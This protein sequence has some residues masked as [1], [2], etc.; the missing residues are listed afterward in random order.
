MD[1]ILIAA[2]LLYMFV[3]IIS[4]LCLLGFII[5]LI[6]QFAGILFK[7]TL[8]GIATVLIL[9]TLGWLIA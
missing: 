9:T 6:V 5:W 3:P 2:G 1:N 8:V 4:A 7:F